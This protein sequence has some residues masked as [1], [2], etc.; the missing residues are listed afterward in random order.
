[1]KI[2]IEFDESILIIVSFIIMASLV[3]IEVIRS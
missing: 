1:M 3:S 2:N